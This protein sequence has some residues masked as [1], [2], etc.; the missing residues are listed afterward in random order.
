M[1]SVE[2]FKCIKYYRWS[3][4]EPTSEF[5]NLYPFYLHRATKDERVKVLAYL[6]LKILPPAGAFD[7][8]MVMSHWNHFHFVSDLE[9]LELTSK[10]NC[11]S[12]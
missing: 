7:E 10:R 1:L 3:V 4:H 12:V 2:T 9:D 8:V 5:E 6:H 11:F